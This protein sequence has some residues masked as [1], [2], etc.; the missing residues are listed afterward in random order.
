MAG[1][2]PSKESRQLDVL[3]CHY[4]PHVAETVETNTTDMET[5]GIGLRL[6]NCVTV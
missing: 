6:V 5:Y 4:P 2:S 3:N 1:A